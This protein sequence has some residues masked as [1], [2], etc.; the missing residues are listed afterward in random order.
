MAGIILVSENKE[1]Q[2]MLR[3]AQRLLGKIPSIRFVAL[4]PG[5]SPQAMQ[6]A[7]LKV[8]QQFEEKEILL[9]TDV[10]GSTQWNVCMSFSKRGSIEIV[11]GYNLP[12]IIKLGALRE[13][14]PL[15]KLIPFIEQY[16]REQIR[17]CCQGK[18]SSRL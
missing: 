16:G 9:L 12:M 7:L 1:A 13:K 15:K 6:E 10:Y 8:I 3:A 14:L 2:E 17:H 4:K 18:R 11:T 5:Q